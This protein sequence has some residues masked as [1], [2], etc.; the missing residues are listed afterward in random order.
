MHTSTRIFT[1]PFLGSGIMAIHIFLLCALFFKYFTINIF[2]NRK[3]PSFYI[4][5]IIN[6]EA[7]TSNTTIGHIIS[8]S[9]VFF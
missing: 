8:V 6:L 1:N 2:L 3:K 7:I 9:H 5:K 4:Y